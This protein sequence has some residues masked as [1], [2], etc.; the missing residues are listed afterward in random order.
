MAN[1]Y[2]LQ[3]LYDVAYGIIAQGQDSTAYPL[4]LMRSFLNKAQNDICY[5]NVQ[6]LSTNERLEKQTLSFLNKN[7]FYTTHNYSTLS[8]DCVVGATTIA[9]NSQN[10]ATSW[11]LWINGAIISYTGNTGTSLTGVPTTW[12]H[13]IPFAFIWGTQVY[14]IDTLPTDFGQMTRAFLTLNTTK[15]RTQLVPVDER[16]LASPIPNSSIY[17]FFF[18]R[19]YSNSTGLGMEWY[20]S[21]LNGSFVFFLVPQTN[22]QPISFDYQKAP[23][24]L[25]LPADTLTIP[26]EYALNTIPYMA[27]SEMMAN[28]WEMDEAIKLNNFWFNNIKSMYQFYQSQ[29]WELQYNTRVRTSSDGFFNV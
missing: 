8:S 10:L 20:Y 21:I 1:T 2:T 4:T 9:C 6:N 13:S 19:S 14:Q 29:R 11:F 15:Y 16:D 5:G 7:T 22:L 12:T 24:Q 25:S 3:H 18:D 27:V 28:R 23:V 26:D 17:R